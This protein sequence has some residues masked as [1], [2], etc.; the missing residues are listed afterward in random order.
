MNWLHFNEEPVHNCI[1]FGKKD[2][3][4]NTFFVYSLLLVLASEFNHRA[5]LCS[6]GNYSLY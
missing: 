6:A 1:K 3:I 2:T 4:L 5:V